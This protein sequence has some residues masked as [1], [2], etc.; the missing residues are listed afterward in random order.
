MGWV[1]DPPSGKGVVVYCHAV[2]FFW[3]E[4]SLCQSTWLLKGH[5]KESAVKVKASTR[6]ASGGE[7]EATNGYNIGSLQWF[8][9]PHVSD[10]TSLIIFM[11]SIWN[12]IDDRSDSCLPVIIYFCVFISEF[13]VWPPWRTQK[14]EQLIWSRFQGHISHGQ[15][16]WPWRCKSQS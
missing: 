3:W 13:G 16:P 9:N 10:C 14:S 6:K 15:G 1:G 2:K 12:R 4:H 11:L 7:V 5:V 8:G